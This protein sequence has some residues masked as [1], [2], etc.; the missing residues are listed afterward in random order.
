MKTLLIQTLLLLFMFQ[1]TLSQDIHWEV[2]TNLNNAR[3]IQVMGDTLFLATTGGLVS[4][5][6]SGENFRRITSEAGLSDHTFQAMT[7]SEKDML[8]LGTLYG[9]LTFYD[10][11]SG[12]ASEDFSLDGNEIVGLD[13]VGDTLWIATKSM[14]A[15]YLFDKEKNVFNF[16]DFFRNFNRNFDSFSD[17]HYFA[18]RIWVA[19]NNG[20][21][22]APG[23]FLRNNLKAAENW[24]IITD[25]DGLPGNDI[26]SLTSWSD[27]LY[28]G[29]STGLSKYNFQNFRNFGSTSMRNLLVRQDNLYMDNSRNIY[30][31]SG[32]QFQEI[33][34]T[35]INTINDFDF[36]ESGNLWVSLE[37][38]GL[39][40]PDTGEKIK[41]NSPIDNTMGNMTLNSRGELWLMSGIYNDQRGTGF[42]VLRSNGI[43]ENYR[44][45]SGW[46]ATSNTQRAI[47]D[48]EGNMWIGSWNGGLIIITPQNKFYHFNNYS[49]PGKLWISSI[50]R[51]D[52]L[53][54]D[55]PDSVRH[56]LSYTFNAPDLL[57][58]TDFEMDLARQCL[59]VMTPAVRSLEPLVCYQGTAFNASAFDSTTWEKTGFPDQLSLQGSPAAAIATDVF[60]NIWVGTDRQGVIYRQEN[61]GTL[62]WFRFT[63]SNNL[64][65]NSSF[66]IAGD[67]DGYVWIGT[68]SGLNAY[69]NGNIFDFREEYQPIGLTIN[70][71]FV[72]SENNKW[73]ATDRG[74]SLLLSRGSPFDPGSWRHF[75]PRRSDLVGSNIIKSN[76]PDQ[77]IR[78]VYVDDNTGDV[79]ASTIAG[80]AILRSN[81]FTTP[82]EK[83]E[84]VKVGPTPLLVSEGRENYVYF[85]NLTANAELKI[86]TATGRLVRTINL[87]NSTD[88]FGSFARWNCR[89]EEGRL[90]SSGVYV[91]L[92]TDE[93]GNSGSGKFMIIRE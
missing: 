77:N 27:T 74:L 55:P 31:L 19:S 51:D 26:L 65:N 32:S 82:L 10:W 53:T 6:L 72:D 43:W 13:A 88:F 41:F 44:Y 36:D 85:R 5:S 15:V 49:N 50:N 18:G 9:S 40:N 68:P 33:Y 17:I 23:N 79:Y 81:P 8:I 86:L 39:I 22:Y 84:T 90:V 4:Y 83:L 30:R 61:N 28:I 24:Q 54:V 42:S 78:S 48:T 76:L 45:F 1:P 47:E 70:E 11:N 73:F 71:I 52:T 91:F 66:A 69:L 7:L 21:F 63:E 37:K 34:R 57:V 25:V 75:V 92:V 80:L 87:S 93:Q 14:V 3:E 58:V 2:I 46:T 64:K 29:T 16:R 38:K 60:N 62:N 56:F 59:W 20:L 89:N 12:M 67:Q 35:S